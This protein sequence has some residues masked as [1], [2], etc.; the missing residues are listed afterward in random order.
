MTGL[1]N[2]VKTVRFRA[3]DR[4]RPRWDMTG[5]LNGVKTPPP[6]RGFGLNWLGYDR[7]FERG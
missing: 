2:G 7:T 4:G 3:S 1:L 5:L 6:P